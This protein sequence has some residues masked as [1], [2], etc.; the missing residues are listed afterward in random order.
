MSTTKKQLHVWVRP[1][2]A[3][4]VRQEAFNRRLSGA[5]F[6]ANMITQEMKRVEARENREK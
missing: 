6:I 2:I 4:W 3:E 1:E 5:A